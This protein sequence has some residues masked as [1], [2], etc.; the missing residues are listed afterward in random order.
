MQ[1]Q[2]SPEQ[3]KHIDPTQLRCNQR[4]VRT[5]RQ[6]LTMQKLAASTV[7][8]SLGELIGW[9]VTNEFYAAL[10]KH[11]DP[12]DEYCLPLFSVFVLGHDI[13]QERQAIHISLSS[14]WF[15]FN[16]IRALECGWVVQLNGDGTFG[17]CRADVDI[18]LGSASAQLAAQTIPHA[19]PTFRI[20]LRESSCTL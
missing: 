16:A 20:E 8:E 4:C 18:C 2:G 1:A 3:Y 9:C 13:K 14:P 11:N 10:R 6:Q 5:A 19:G 12:A 17:F 7:P 15:L